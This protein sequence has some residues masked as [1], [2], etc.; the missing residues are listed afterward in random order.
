MTAELQIQI[1]AHLYVDYTQKALIPSLELA[2]IE[3]LN[4]NDGGIL[5]HTG[6]FP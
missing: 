2:L 4:G 3:D 5:D 1:A 6:I